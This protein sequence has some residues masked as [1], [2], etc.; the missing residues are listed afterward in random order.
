MEQQSFKEYM[1][2]RSHK[3]YMIQEGPFWDAL[4]HGVA[5]GVKAYSKKRKELANKSE[6]KIMTSKILGAEGKDLDVLLKQIV[7]NGYTIKNGAVQ[8]PSLL[9]KSTDWLI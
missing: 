6:V 5:T 8:K 2:G 1:V 7:D 4:K 9:V 3:E